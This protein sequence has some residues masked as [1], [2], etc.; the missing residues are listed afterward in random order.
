MS[1][2]KQRETKLRLGELARVRV[3][4]VHVRAH[5]LRRQPEN[6]ARPARTTSTFVV[7]NIHSRHALTISFSSRKDKFFLCGDHCVS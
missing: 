4:H 3:H 6:G 5:S 2:Q 7:Q 1:E